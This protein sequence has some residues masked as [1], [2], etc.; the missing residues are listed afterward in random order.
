MFNIGMTYVRSEGVPLDKDELG[1]WFY[2][3]STCSLPKAQNSFVQEVLT[4]KFA[5]ESLVEIQK[6]AQQWIETHPKID[7]RAIG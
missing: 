5:P 6:R 2:L 3:C 4:T 1:F 7:F